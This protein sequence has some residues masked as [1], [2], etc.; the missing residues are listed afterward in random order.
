MV[1]VICRVCIVWL[2]LL[3]FP[4]LANDKLRVAYI[5]VPPYSF[6]D[7]NRQPRGQLIERFKDIAQALDME[8]EFIYL[9]HR[10]LIQFIEGGNV[11]MW[12]GLQRSRINSDVSIMSKQTLFLMQLDA[13]WKKGTE[14]V[15]HFDALIN[16]DLV[17]ISSYSYGGRYSQLATK[18]RNI[19]YALNHED[20]FDQLMTLNGFY[21][22]GYKDIAQEVIDKFSIVGFEQSSLATYELYLKIA[23][24]YPNAKQ[25]MDKVDQYLIAHPVNDGNRAASR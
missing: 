15:K 6:Q 14:P 13:F 5:D 11:D 8:A 7:T 23:K 12:A 3:T 10:R 24:H 1:R 18:S 19:R 16:R 17:L 9:P 4:S 25:L 20:G 2:C 21:L 22:L